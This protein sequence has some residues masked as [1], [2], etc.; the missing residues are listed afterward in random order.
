[1]DGRE[2][3]RWVGRRGGWWVDRRESDE[4][5]CMGGR[6]VGGYVGGHVHIITIVIQVHNK[7]FRCESNTTH[8]SPH[9]MQ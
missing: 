5:V 9:H 1:M 3:G 8:Y 6:W 7:L 4:C 2:D